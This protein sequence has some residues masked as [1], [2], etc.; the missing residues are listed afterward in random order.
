V[1]PCAVSPWSPPDLTKIPVKLHLNPRLALLALHFPIFKVYKIL[2]CLLIQALKSIRPECFQRKA[3]PA[4]T[5]RRALESRVIIETGPTTGMR[6]LQKL[7]ID[8]YGASNWELKEQKRLFCLLLVSFY[9][10]KT[11]PI[12]RPKD[13]S[14][15]CY[16]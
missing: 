11:G 13:F 4:K 6:S 7:T 2:R 12:V 5:R 1:K 8:Q 16:P 15:Q 3:P 9:W 14:G 10:E